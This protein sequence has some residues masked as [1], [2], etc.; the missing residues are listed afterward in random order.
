MKREVIGIGIAVFLYLSYVVYCMILDRN[1]RRYSYQENQSYK[2][3][4]VLPIKLSF[5]NYISL[6]KLLRDIESR[7]TP[8][9][10]HSPRGYIFPFTFHPRLRPLCG[11][12]Q[13]LLLL[14][15]FFIFQTTQDSNI[16][17]SRLRNHREGQRR[18]L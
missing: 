14:W 3:F 7:H 18:G 8:L 17:I 9:E 15:S 11:L 1:I 5:L 6:V 4:P 10:L 13:I 16:Y 2:D 12:C